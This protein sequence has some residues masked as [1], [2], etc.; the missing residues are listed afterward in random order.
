MD[1][2]VP[3]VEAPGNVSSNSVRDLESCISLARTFIKEMSIRWS[4]YNIPEP[5]TETISNFYANKMR[6]TQDLTTTTP[7]GEEEKQQHLQQQQMKRLGTAMDLSKILDVA[8]GLALSY[9]LLELDANVWERAV[10]M[11]NERRERLASM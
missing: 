10:N 2:L 4:L 1:T 5:L 8:R 9:G 6:S 7:E 3:L 11:E